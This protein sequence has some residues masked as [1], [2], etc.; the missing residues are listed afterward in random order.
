VVAGEIQL[1]PGHQRG[2]ACQKIQG[3]VQ[4]VCSVVV[5]VF[6]AGLAPEC[7]RILYWPDASTRGE[8]A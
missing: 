4:D 5:V 8:N 6:R 7:E 1:W 2:Q 3:L